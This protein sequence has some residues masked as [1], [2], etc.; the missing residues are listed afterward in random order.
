MGR[1]VWGAG[2]GIMERGGGG[3]GWGGAR[4]S[5]A[6]RHFFHGRTHGTP[7]SSSSY[8]THVAAAALLPSHP[9]Q[10]THLAVYRL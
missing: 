4:L 10:H 3:A 9:T 1:G 5:S 6:Q 8:S 2:W 7:L